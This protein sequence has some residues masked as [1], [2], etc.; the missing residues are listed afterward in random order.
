[1]HVENLCNFLDT[2]LFTKCEILKDMKVVV[3]TGFNF[4]KKKEGIEKHMKLIG[5]ISQ[6]KVI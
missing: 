2:V 3:E 5:C 4:V 1:M 6:E